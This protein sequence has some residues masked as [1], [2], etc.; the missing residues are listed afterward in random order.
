[1]I[2]VLPTGTL[3]NPSYLRFYY[4]TLQCLTVAYKQMEIMDM[5]LL[6]GEGGARTKDENQCKI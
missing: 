4:S 5:A 2:D 6:G 3:P 1:M